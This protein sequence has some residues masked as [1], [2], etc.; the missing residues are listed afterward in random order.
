MKRE[1]IFIVSKLWNQYHR[2]EN[3]KPALLRTL[4]DMK[5]DYLDLY[6]IH[7][8]ISLKYVDPSVRPASWIHDPTI[9]KPRME[10]DLSVTYQQTWAAM[11]EL[12]NEG[13][14]KNIGVSNIGVDKLQDVLKYAKVKPAVLQV[15]MHPHLTQDRLKRF[16]QMNGVQVMAYSQFG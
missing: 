15:E 1:D 9:K 3:V 11:E 10:L 2:P 13:L 7:F 5:V 6:L 14:V 16:A 8:P 4:K 12:V